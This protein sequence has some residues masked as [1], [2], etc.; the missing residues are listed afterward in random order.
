MSREE[1]RHDV[2]IAKEVEDLWA[3][4]K[5]ILSRLDQIDHKMCLLATQTPSATSS[6]EEQVLKPFAAGVI[7]APGMTSQPVSS[8]FPCSPLPSGTCRTPGLSIP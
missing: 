1:S 6:Q 4:Q 8:V 2:G 7:G 5:A 3:K